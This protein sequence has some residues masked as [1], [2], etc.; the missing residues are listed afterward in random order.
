VP[1]FKE[2]LI[3]CF[4]CEGC[5]F[6]DV[7]V[8]GGGAVP[9]RGTVHTLRVAAGGG[10]G[11]DLARDV[12]KGD[13]AAVEVPELALTVVAGSMG[14]L[15]TTVEGLLSAI[16]DNLQASD[17]YAAGAVDSGGADLE[18]RRAR[19]ADFLARL[20]RCID[21][22]DAFTLILRDP[23][24]NSWVFSP[25]A[26]APGGPAA[27]AA[28]DVEE[29]TRSEHEDRHLGLLDM[30]TEDYAEAHAAE[31]LAREQANAQAQAEGSHA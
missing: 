22:T 30:K 7:E 2:V 16:R 21:G 11:A 13:T 4:K 19:M 9:A 23:M 14:G 8:K 1:H 6:R 17:P 29:Y 20:G 18:P 12:I 3:A 28:L 31:L 10:G 15:Y 5:G 26:D 27:D 25:A 24:A